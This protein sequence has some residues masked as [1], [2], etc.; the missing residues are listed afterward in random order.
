MGTS[1][2][3]PFSLG[4]TSGSGEGFLQRIIATTQDAVVFIDAEARIVEF[5]PAAEEMFGYSAAEAI[6]KNVKI[7]MPEPYRSEHDGYIQKYEA[8]GEARAI[9]RIRTVKGR[10]RSGEVFLLEL[11]VTRLPDDEVVRY[12]AFLRDVSEKV[13]LQRKLIEKERLASLGTASAMLAHEIGNPLNNMF[14]EAQLLARKVRK[15]GAEADYGR[16]TTSILEE[17]ARLRTL[18]D[19]F[20]SIAQAVA[21]KFA[22]CSLAEVVRYTARHSEQAASLAAVRIECD[23]CDDGTILGD[24]GKLKQVFHN[25]AKNAIEAMPG[26]GTLVMT[27]REDDEKVVAEVSDTGTGLPDGIDLFDLFTTTKEQGTGLGLAIVR[28]LV[29]THNGSIAWADNEG[30]GAR[31]TLVF[32]KLASAVP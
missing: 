10:H 27:V 24:A 31:F 25:L 9:G 19:E 18:L 22:P 30:G 16:A 7:L 3:Q 4:S 1:R 6:G 2:R 15:R 14:L 12:A 11:S 28:Q 17:I 8:T 32:P 26:G 13:E 5:N 29:A 20:R 21:A 23:L